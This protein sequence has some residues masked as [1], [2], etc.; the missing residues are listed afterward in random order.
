MKA[1]CGGCRDVLKADLV[2]ALLGEDV[3]ILTKEERYNGRKNPLSKQNKRSVIARYK[4][5]ESMMHLAEYYEVSYGLVN[6]IIPKNLH[7]KV[8]RY[9]KKRKRS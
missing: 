2:I 7:R 1:V 8:G 4:R 9:K 6:K 3:P 5:G